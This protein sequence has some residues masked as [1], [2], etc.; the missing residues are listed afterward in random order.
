MPALHH[1]QARFLEGGGSG[2]ISGTAI[3]L[4]VCIGLIPAIAL[5]WVVVWLLFFYGK[6]RNCCCMKRK[7]QTTETDTE[8]SRTDTSQETLDEKAVYNPPP[9]PYIPHTR[10]ESGSSADTGR[11]SRSDPNTR[12]SMNSVQG[13]QEPK[14]FV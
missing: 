2:G 1:L 13:V 6:G 8:Q 11:F 10:T 14:R 9:R 12:M 5:I 7:K 4:I 3:A